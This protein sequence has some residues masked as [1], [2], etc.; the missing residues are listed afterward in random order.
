MI[1]GSA[2]PVI[3]MKDMVDAYKEM[4]APEVYEQVMY[5]NAAR[6]LKLEK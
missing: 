5:E 3:C 2:Y 6:I 4:L 1:F